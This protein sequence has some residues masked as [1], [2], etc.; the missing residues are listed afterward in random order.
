MRRLYSR[1]AKRTSGPVTLQGT[2]L[3]SKR[4]DMPTVIAFP[5]LLED[6]RSLLPLFN[7]TFSEYRNLWL[8]SYRNSWNTERSDNMEPEQVAD[9][10]IRFMDSKRITTASLVGHGYGAKIATQTGVLKYHRITSVVGL[11]YSPQ[12]Y[13]LH[14]AWLDLK[15]AVEFA[16]KIDLVKKSKE[17]VELIIKKGVPNHRLAKNLLANLEADREGVYWKSGVRELATLMNAKDERANIGKFPL[18]GCFPGRALFLYAERGQWVHQSSNTIPIYNIFPMLLQEYGT[19]I[20]HV[21]TDNHYLHET[22]DV[23]SIARR[24][25][26]FYKWFD[27]V[28]PLLRDRSEIGKIAVPVRARSDLTPAEAELLVEEGDPTRPKAIPLHRHHNWGYQ[29]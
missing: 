14:K 16:A 27:G 15:Q 18:I 26:D 11:D 22:S 23:K 6:P 28:H 5:D 7:S 21:D 1:I 20:D 13:S 12:D 2:F 17:E 3:P 4:R 10:V 9:D 25:T 8:L 29:H 19:F 24:I